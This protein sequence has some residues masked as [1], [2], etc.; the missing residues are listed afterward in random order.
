VSGIATLASTY[1]LDLVA[2]A[3]GVLIAATR[4]LAGLPAPWLFAVLAV[5]YLAWAL[6]LRTNLGAAGYEYLRGRG[7][8]AYLHHRTRS[9][10][11]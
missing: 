4:L 10:G 7:T 6:G 8:T 11:S 9:S 1:A 3:A 2:T 5:S